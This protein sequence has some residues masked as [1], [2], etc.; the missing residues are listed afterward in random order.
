MRARD[1]DTC[2]RRDPRSR[3]RRFNDGA[4]CKD[5]DLC[6]GNFE[7]A[8]L[9][10]CAFEGT[11]V[12]DIT[13]LEKAHVKLGDKNEKAEAI[14]LDIAHWSNMAYLSTRLNQLKS[15]KYPAEFAARLEEKRRI[16]REAFAEGGMTA[17]I[18]RLRAWQAAGDEKGFA[19]LPEGLV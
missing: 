9:T 8:T 14:S 2:A 5:A 19:L 12:A 17:A 15:A 3:A 13:N 18:K 1:G 7:G 11:C 4:I 6:R 16:C 10:R